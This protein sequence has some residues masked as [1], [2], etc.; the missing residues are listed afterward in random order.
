[1][2]AMAIALVLLFGA[3]VTPLGLVN[4]HGLAAVSALDH[5]D[6]WSGDDD[7]GH[8]HEEDDQKYPSS[9]AHHGGDHSHEHAHALPVGLPSLS[10]PAGI[11]QSRPI[12][13]VTWPSLD[14]LD[15][16]PRA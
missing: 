2:L 6:A 13:S 12:D 5:G 10:G 16:P 8:S 14:G 4:S 1:M 3:L 11:W 9:H 15:R 7:H